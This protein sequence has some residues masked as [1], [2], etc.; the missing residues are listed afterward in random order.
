MDYG[1]AGDGVETLQLTLRTCYGMSDVAVD[2]DFGSITRSAL[3]DV[4][5]R[6]GITPDG[7][8][9]EQTYR[10]LKWPRY[11][12]GSRNGCAYTGY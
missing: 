10:N 5:G 12:D 7:L 3:I 2:G 9:G 1:S 8:Y 4:Q 6:E 11:T